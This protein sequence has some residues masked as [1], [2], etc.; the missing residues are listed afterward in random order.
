VNEEVKNE[1]PKRTR[2]PLEK[3]F[4]V[5]ES[6]AGI[7]NLSD[8]FADLLYTEFCHESETTGNENNLDGYLPGQTD[9]ARYGD[10]P[11]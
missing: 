2:Y 6:Y 4:I 3:V 7:K 1:T 10:T 11:R 5:N 8:I 9:Q